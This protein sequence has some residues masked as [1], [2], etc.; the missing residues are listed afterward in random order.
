MAS[1]QK[2]LHSLNH[3][4]PKNDWSRTYSSNLYVT[5][6]LFTIGR[7]ICCHPWKHKTQ[8]V[9]W[10]CAMYNNRMLG[11][12][13]ENFFALAAGD[14]QTTFHTML[15]KRRASKSSPLFSLRVRTPVG[16]V[17]VSQRQSVLTRMKRY[18]KASIIIFRTVNY[19]SNNKPL[20]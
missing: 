20:S 13:T 7:C 8:Q 18:R 5:S 16:K 2:T 10:M 11:R 12:S 4:T 15:G 9:S 1:F 17:T 3:I 6:L 19:C 14:I